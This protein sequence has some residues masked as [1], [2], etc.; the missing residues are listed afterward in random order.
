MLSF[1]QDADDFRPKN[2]F[3]NIQEVDIVKTLPVKKT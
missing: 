3:K 2:R 1:N